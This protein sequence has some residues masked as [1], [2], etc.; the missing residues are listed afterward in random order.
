M[1]LFPKRFGD[2]FTRA[3]TAIYGCGFDYRNRC[4]GGTGMIG[5]DWQNLAGPAW[6]FH[7]VIAAFLCRL[8]CSLLAEFASRIPSPGGVNSMPY[9]LRV[10]SLTS[11]WLSTVMKSHDSRIRWPQVGLCYFKWLLADLL[12]FADGNVTLSSCNLWSLTILVMVLVTALS[13]ECK[14]V[15][16]FHPLVLPSSSAL[17]PV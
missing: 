2:R 17:L 4:H 14:A 16:R 13:Y 8:I 3:K 10:S 9:L 7:L 1:N 6:S 15:L 12:R 5:V 11:L